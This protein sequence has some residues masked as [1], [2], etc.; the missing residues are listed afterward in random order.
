[1]TSPWLTPLEACQ[2]LKLDQVYATQALFRIV[3]QAV[4]KRK[5]IEGVKKLGRREWRFTTDFLDRLDTRQ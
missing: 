4:K 1:M 3:R 2:Y 5:D